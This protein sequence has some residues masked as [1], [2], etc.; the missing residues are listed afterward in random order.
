M[1]VHA[2]SRVVLTLF[3]RAVSK[4]CLS[5]RLKALVLVA[6]V[7]WMNARVIHP[8]LVSKVKI[9]MAI[10]CY[11][12]MSS[13]TDKALGGCRI[14][15]LPQGLQFTVVITEGRPEGANVKMAAAL[16]E[17][18]V[19]TIAILDSGV[20]WAFDSLKYNTWLC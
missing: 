18:G 1:L 8:A 14:E 17:L 7:N 20:A 19:K 3:K 13:P 5:L 16:V 11:V 4:A 15:W 2:Y 10:R 6:L 12:H 9:R